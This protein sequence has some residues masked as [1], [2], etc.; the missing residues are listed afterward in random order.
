M[1]FT[2]DPNHS[3]RSM[4]FAGVPVAR[5]RV[6]QTVRGRADLAPADTDNTAAT[7]EAW[8]DHQRPYLLPDELAGPAMATGVLAS[9]SEVSS[10]DHSVGLD[11][12]ARIV[13]GIGYNL[14]TKTTH[15]VLATGG[16]HMQVTPYLD[17]VNVASMTKANSV[18]AFARQAEIKLPRV[19]APGQPTANQQAQ[20]ATYNQLEALRWEI[21]KHAAQ[22][23]YGA[24]LHGLAR[25]VC[26]THVLRQAGLKAKRTRHMGVLAM[27]SCLTAE[28]PNL[29]INDLNER[30]WLYLCDELDPR[31]RAFLAM[32]VRGLQ[33]YADPASGTIYSEL[34]SEPENDADNQGITFVRKSGDL[35]QP[36]P[37]PADYERVLAAPDLCLAYYYAYAGSLGIGHQAT[38]VLLQTML[39]P[40]VWG[41]NARLPYRASFPKLDAATYLLRS[42]DTA[43]PSAVVAHFGRMLATGP[44]IA[45]RFLASLGSVVSGFAGGRK[46]SLADVMAQVVG[47]LADPDQARSLLRLVWSH[48][49]D[50]YAA[51]E[52][53][54]PFWS[55]V[56]E[57]FDACI[58]A[59]RLN[60]HLISQCRA[61]PSQS[62]RPVFNG[63]VD[64]RDAIIGSDLRGEPDAR[65]C[66]SVIYQLVAGVPLTCQ[67]EPPSGAMYGP[68][69][70]R[71]GVLRSWRAVVTWVRYG[72]E[73]A[74]RL[75]LE[76]EEPPRRESKSSESSAGVVPALTFTHKIPATTTEQTKPLSDPGLQPKSLFESA[77]RWQSPATP[78][79]DHAKRASIGSLGSG[80]RR[81]FLRSPPPAPP[82]ATYRSPPRSDAPTVVALP[83][84][85]PPAPPSTSDEMSM[86]GVLP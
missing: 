12:A 3:W 66:E 80:N 22:A 77:S 42:T 49:S 30:C 61:T 48:A 70:E 82:P 60:A 84:E 78:T 31:Y 65:Y 45:Q 4:A 24:R 75:A 6:T 79:V 52:W 27:G 43:P 53:V 18:E 20:G 37:D 1:S 10:A 74:K 33:H 8:I 26:H 25:V 40:H 86:R 2:R 58:A 34:R 56:S 38:Q 68:A 11:G 35:R 13:T 55:G 50:G 63:G 54:N 51:L 29:A 47:V 76:Q 15:A 32:G 21:A 85:A 7:L 57:A 5:A 64:M 16:A 17:P 28:T 83:A 44:V 62:I 36:H 14:R 46:V 41:E 39:G 81:D 59:Y 69:P 23:D 71:L 72:L 9:V 73:P 67:C 19:L